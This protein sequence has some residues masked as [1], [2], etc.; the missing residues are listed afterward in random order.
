MT[1]IYRIVTFGDEICWFK[2]TC[3]N[4]IHIECQPNWSTIAEVK[5]FFS[6]WKSDFDRLCPWEGRKE[7]VLWNF[8]W[9][10]IDWT[11]VLISRHYSC[12]AK[13]SV[14]PQPCYSPSHVSAPPTWI[15]PL[16]THTI[17]P[18]HPYYW[19]WPPL[20]LPLLT[21]QQLLFGRVFDLVFLLV[22][23]G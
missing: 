19:P 22:N 18:G 17:D 4:A 8:V 11:E 5:A 20:L 12:N 21:C 23:T 6:C 14:Q 16:P 13:K 7:A 3:V 1:M 15:L 10:E 9:R 2:V